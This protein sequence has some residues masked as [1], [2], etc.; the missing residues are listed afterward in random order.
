MAFES[1]CPSTPAGVD[2]FHAPHGFSRQ[3]CTAANSHALHKSHP[4]LKYLSILLHRPSKKKQPFKVEN[5]SYLA[6]PYSQIE[7]SQFSC[8]L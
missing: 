2:R 7:Y 5:F 4:P 6:I 1:L 8:C 3:E